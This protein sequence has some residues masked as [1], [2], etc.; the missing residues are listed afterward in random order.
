MQKSEE[1]KAELELTQRELLQKK[2]ELEQKEFDI[3]MWKDSSEKYTMVCSGIYLLLR[4]LTPFL[5]L[6]FFF[7]L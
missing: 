1:K 3:Q 5:F 2:L 6:F 7:F 4:V